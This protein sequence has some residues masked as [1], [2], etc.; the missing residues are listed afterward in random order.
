MSSTTLVCT[1]GSDVAIRAAVAGL[2]VLRTGDRIVIVTVIPQPALTLPYDASGMGGAVI[3]PDEVVQI[4]QDLQAGG[5]EVVER[6]A[7]AIGVTEYESRILVGSAGRAIC[8]LAEEL[9]ASVVLLG[10]RGH[11]GLKRA[12]LGSVSDHVVRHSPCPVLV[13]PAP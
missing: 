1:D 8:E 13:V 9:A 10:S 5:K 12:L 7:A 2:A 4:E 3:T 11:G 6:T